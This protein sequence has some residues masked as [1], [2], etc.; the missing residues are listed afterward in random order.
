MKIIEIT[1]RDECNDLITV[2]TKM[3]GVESIEERQSPGGGDRWYWTIC[4]TDGGT[5]TIFDPQLLR[6]K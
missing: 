3:K 1:F 6:R 4:F 2:S 5:L